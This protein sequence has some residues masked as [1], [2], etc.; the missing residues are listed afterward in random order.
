MA[1]RHRKDTRQAAARINPSWQ[2]SAQYLVYNFAACGRRVAIRSLVDV[3]VVLRLPDRLLQIGSNI[4]AAR[5][6]SSK[7]VVSGRNSRCPVSKGTSK[8]SRSMQFFRATLGS[9]SIKRF[10]NFNCII[11]HVGSN[12]SAALYLLLMFA[13]VLSGSDRRSS[14]A[15]LPCAVD[16]V[17]IRNRFT[18]VRTRPLSFQEFPTPGPNSSQGLRL[19]RRAVLTPPVRQPRNYRLIWTAAKQS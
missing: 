1:N 16:V 9:R 8:T 15:G 4:G 3:G 17:P 10:Y 14:H 11:R 6:R 5:D 12:M 19:L 2:K 18:P 7:A 13:P